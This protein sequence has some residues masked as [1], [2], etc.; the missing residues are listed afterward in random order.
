MRPIRRLHDGF[1]L[2]RGVKEVLEHY[3]KMDRPMALATYK[4]R[5]ATEKIMKALAFN[6]YFD[7]LVTADDVKNPKPHP[8]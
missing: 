5:S 3:Q 1:E 7:Y 8:R 6:Q 2:R 4:I